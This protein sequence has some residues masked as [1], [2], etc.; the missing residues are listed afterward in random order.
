MRP[1]LFDLILGL[2]KLLTSHLEGS[3]R[4][5]H[6]VLRSTLNSPRLV[7]Q[8]VTLCTYDTPCLL[9][10]AQTRKEGA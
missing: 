1:P 9:A 8:C 5:G 4:D 7:K 10:T 6:Q 2:Y 3:L